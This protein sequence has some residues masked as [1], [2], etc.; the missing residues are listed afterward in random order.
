M[1]K[2]LV[3]FLQWAAE[4]EMQERKQM[5]IKVMLF[6][7]VFSLFMYVAKKRIWARLDVH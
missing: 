5:G 4:P 3:N 7:A 1:A 6:L 2:D